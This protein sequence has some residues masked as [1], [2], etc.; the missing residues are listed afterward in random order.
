MVSALEVFCVMVRLFSSFDQI[1]SQTD[2]AIKKD[3]FF[4]TLKVLKTTL[5]LQ[6]SVF[7]LRTL[8]EIK[9]YTIALFME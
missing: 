5:Y 2:E 7:K 6:D 4:K 1:E 8:E 9:D 3:T